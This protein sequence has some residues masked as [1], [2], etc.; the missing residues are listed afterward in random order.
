MAKYHI[1]ERGEPA[2]CAARI[3]CPLG[4]VLEHFDTASDARKAYE[5]FMSGTEWITA[6]KD[7]AQAHWDVFGLTE[8]VT[9]EDLARFPSATIPR[10]SRIG[11]KAER[12][13]YIEW[14][15]SLS[16]EEAEALYLYK[17]SKSKAINDYLRGVA[18]A[19]LELQR[20]VVNLNE[21][22]ARNATPQTD[23]YYYGLQ[24][25]SLTETE[26][27]NWRK[28][29]SPGRVLNF[30]HF[31]SLSASP[32]TADVYRGNQGVLFEVSTPG[33]LF[34]DT[35]ETESIVESNSVW[36]V[37]NLSTITDSKRSYEVIQIV[38]LGDVSG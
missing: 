20:A 27:E 14:T 28:E 24:V 16:P 32:F 3:R 17:S 33:A 22:I 18:P 1:N 13:Q 6:K 2:F 23:V 15:M 37:A 19:A 31:V 9:E 10:I 11:T 12:D 25:R 35:E 5:K 38:R 21:L 8:A 36:K 30:K 26:L 7:S 29:F 34:T 4:G